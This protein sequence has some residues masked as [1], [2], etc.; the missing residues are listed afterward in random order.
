[1]G[2]QNI[3]KANFGH[4]LIFKKCPQ[5]L[6][7]KSCF[8]KLFNQNLLILP[9]LVL[10]LKEFTVPSLL[11][12]Q[13]DG[14]V[15]KPVFL[16]KPWN[17]QFSKLQPG[18]RTQPPKCAIYKFFSQLLVPFPCPCGTPFIKKNQKTFHT[19]PCFRM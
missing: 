15:E 1:M 13:N 11:R 18:F 9:C 2:P 8:K 16:A 3:Y 7:T 10:L 12:R 4:F 14:K 5:V 19:F 17:E 6:T